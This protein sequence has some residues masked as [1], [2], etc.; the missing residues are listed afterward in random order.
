MEEDDS[1]YKLHMGVLNG[2]ILGLIGIDG[3]AH[4]V[5]N[6][7]TERIKEDVIAGSILLA[8]GIVSLPY[9]LRKR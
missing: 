3:A 6:R 8:G 4:A 7:D 2:I 9:G 5:S 1:K